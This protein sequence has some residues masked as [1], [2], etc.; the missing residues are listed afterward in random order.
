MKHVNLRLPD[1]LHAQAVQAARADDRSL[2]SWLIALV[3]RTVEGGETVNRSEGG[4]PVPG[5][6]RGSGPSPRP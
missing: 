6:L 1:D 5:P 4:S 3:R 2:N